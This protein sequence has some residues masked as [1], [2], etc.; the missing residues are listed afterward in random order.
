MSLGSYFEKMGEL[1][2]AS[3]DAKPNVLTVIIFNEM[4]L[5]TEGK[6]EQSGQSER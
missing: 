3:K 5:I 1:K 2:D 4:L 6:T